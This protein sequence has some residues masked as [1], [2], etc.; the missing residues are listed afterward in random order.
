VSHKSQR[1]VQ[2]S[3]SPDIPAWARDNLVLKLLDDQGFSLE[4]VY[5]RKFLNGLNSK[6]LIVIKA[7]RRE[8]R[9]WKQRT[10]G[11]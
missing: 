6:P 8:P 9:H 1:G 2:D 10:L 5:D 4:V 7:K 11:Y 3:Y